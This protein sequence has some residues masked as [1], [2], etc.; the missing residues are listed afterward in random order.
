MANLVLID[1]A[2]RDSAY[3]KNHIRYLAKKGLIRGEKHGAIWLV[4]LDGLKEYEA[5][6]RE[7]GTKKFDP[8]KYRK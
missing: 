1:Q 6:M 5:K 3:D 7:L 2:V 4:D 8:T